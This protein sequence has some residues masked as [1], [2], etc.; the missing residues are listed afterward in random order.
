MTEIMESAIE[1]HNDEGLPIRCDVRVPKGT[2]PFPV[3]V[4]LHGFKGFKDWGMFPP[5]ARTL[6]E[7]GLA[8]IAMNTSRNGVGESPEEFTELEAFAKNTPRRE[9]ADVRCVIDAIHEGTFEANIDASRVGL[10]GHSRGGGVVILEAAGDARVE[11]VVT[12]ASIAT[13]YRHT[14]R[15]LKS[16]R[17]S[18]RLDVPNT[19]TGQVLWHDRS[20]LDDLERSRRE[21]DLEAAARGVTVPFLAIHGERDEAVEASSSEELI[22]WSGSSEKRVHILPNTGHTFGCVH[23]WAGPTP[24]WTTA[25]EET[26][27]WFNAWLGV[28]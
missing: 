17:E 20:V 24:A 11:C 4:V 5:T 19:R 10:L 13:F 28:R 22:E 2:G 7:R 18:G 27:A 14:E 6:T 26:A 21:Y 25:V 8:T 3:V 16:W 15:A 9:V 1:I 12:W 23:P